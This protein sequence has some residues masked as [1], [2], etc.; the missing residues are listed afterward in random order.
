MQKLDFTENINQ[1]RQLLKSDSIVDFINNLKPNTSINTNPLTPLIIES[2]S[3][4]DK[5]TINDPKTEILQ[6]L[7]GPALYS[8]MSIGDLINATVNVTIKSQQKVQ[9]FLQQSILS[10][11]H[12]HFTIIQT[13]NL[14]D[15]VLFKDNLSELSNDDT[16][17]FRI[18]IDD[19]LE[20]SRYTKILTL[21][22]ELIEV[23]QK[24]NSD[25]ESKPTIS[26]LDSGSDTNVG[27]KTTVET[28]KSLFQ[29][30]K[31]V[32]DWVVNRK[33]YKSKLRNAGL[34]DNLNVM[35]A[36][37]AAQDNGV[38]DE[39]TAKIY[40]E[41]IIRR[42]EDLLEL[43]VVPKVLIESK[44]EGNTKRLLGEFTEIKMLESGNKGE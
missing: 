26:L 33:F 36:I 25:T 35:V 21:I 19:G 44:A 41:T 28:A 23:I 10:F 3:N 40:K 34:L 2:K 8:E 18:L 27:V 29:I 24:V 17:V 15:H 22:N 43:N 16:I 31:E 32:W 42:T 11:Y 4:F 12:F 1:I 7:N 14:C 30:F 39:N 38:I 9:L 5:I 13:S 20:I 37:K 6:A